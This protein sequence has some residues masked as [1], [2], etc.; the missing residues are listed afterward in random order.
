MYIEPKGKSLMQRLVEEVYAAR[1]KEPVTMQQIL[2]RLYIDEHKS[3]REMGKEMNVSP[4]TISKWLK[5]FGI[6]TRKIKWL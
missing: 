3:V 5:D 6:D 1:W 4:T 2:K